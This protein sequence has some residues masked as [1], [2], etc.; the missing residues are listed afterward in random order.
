[1]S[2]DKVAATMPSGQ[3]LKDIIDDQKGSSS[4]LSTESFTNPARPL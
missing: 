1:M 3:T 2:Q 4:Q